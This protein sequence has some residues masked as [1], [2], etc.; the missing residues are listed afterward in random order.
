MTMGL[1]SVDIMSD[2]ASAAASDCSASACSGA[3][4]GASFDFFSNYGHYMPRMHCL[5]TAEGRPDWLWIGVILALT[6]GV[7]AAYLRIYAFWRRSY[8]AETGPDRNRKLMDLANIFLWCAICGYVMSMVMFFWPAYRLLAVF[9]GVLNWWSWR[10]TRNLGDLRVSLS[11]KRLQR[12]LD[13]HLQNRNA[14]LEKL[15]E[16]R[17]AEAEFARVSA[18]LANRTKSEFLANMSHEIRTPMT[19]IIGY[20][21]LMLDPTQ[22][23]S[24]R[25]DGIQV[26]RRN[27]E[28][29]LCI[30]ND[31]LDLSKIEA[32]KMQ[33][34]SIG[35]SPLALARE[36]RHL[37]Q[38]NAMN[39]GLKLHVEPVFPLPKS[40]MC[41][42]VRLRQILLNLVGNA[43]KFTEAGS[44]TIR[45][46]CTQDRPAC[47]M[48]EVTDTG[49]GM[50]PEQL[51][52][53][54][55]PFTQA[56]T[57]AT[58]RFGGTGLG[59]TISR[60]LARMLGGDLIVTSR[61]GSGSTFTLT[62][63]AG[64]LDGVSML[65]GEADDAEDTRW[66]LNTEAQTAH[67]ANQPL[68]AR[69]LLAEDGADNQ[70]LIGFLLRRSGATVDIAGDGRSAVKMALGS[71]HARREGDPE[72][73]YDLILMDM[74]MPELD[75][76]G[77]ASL[78]RQKGYSGSIIALTA[79]A[80]AGDKEKCQAAGCDDYLTKPVD[81]AKLIEFCR[82]WSGQTRRWLPDAVAGG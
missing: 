52:T 21:D 16:L 13:D 61:P 73:P 35:C 1:S 43:V 33:V 58:R 67:D 24:D 71:M 6:A 30:L 34:E 29:L 17:T 3:H 4:A 5:Q 37:A 57:S 39:K 42:P 45:I 9:L 79:H 81:H 60:R 68:R 36:V 10:F 70:R 56:D 25:V 75:G 22:R 82:R 63:N 31:I 23:P 19:A 8:L 55:Q 80:M 27:A 54:F 40:I 53:L 44:V 72:R 41:D 20:A 76:Y 77:A 46:S 50:T 66:Q 51:G 62:V 49:I 15:V 32:G 11:A 69:I 78:L 48:F 2:S 14:E 28:H 18:E 65:S 12:E 38:M 64:N 47:L 26:I 59:L 74:Q 7:V